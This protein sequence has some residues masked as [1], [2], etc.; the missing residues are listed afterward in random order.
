MFCF[1]KGYHGLMTQV[2]NLQVNPSQSNIFTSQFFL[3]KKRHRLKIPFSKLYFYLSF[4]LFFNSQ[5]Q[6]RYINSTLIRFIYFLL[7]N[8]LILYEYISMWKKFVLIFSVACNY[9]YISLIE[10]MVRATMLLVH[11]TTP[12]KIC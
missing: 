6:L 9:W 7:E 10:W 12:Y 8:I 4:R 5:R 1:L 3:K 11:A 2:V